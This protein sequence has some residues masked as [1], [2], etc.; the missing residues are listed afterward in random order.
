M[1]TVI[2]RALLGPD[3]GGGWYLPH[4]DTRD[5]KADSR[6]LPAYTVAEAAALVRVPV[7]TLKAWIHGGG[8]A[9][10]WA[11]DKPRT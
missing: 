4:V 2:E 11:C 3:R 5:T 10:R 6:E 8:R 1:P 9:S 7:S